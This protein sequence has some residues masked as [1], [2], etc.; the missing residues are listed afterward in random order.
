MIFYVVALVLEFFSRK[1]FLVHLGKDVLGLNTTAQSLL[2]FLNIAEMGIGAAIAFALYRPLFTKDHQAINEILSLMGHFY[3][4][5]AIFVIVGSAV[6]FCFF[7]HIFSKM[8]LPLWYAY[9][10]YGALLTAALVSYWFTYKQVILSA[11]QQNYKIQF[12]Y[13]LPMLI[14][15][16]CQMAAV[17]WLDNGFVWWVALEAGFAIIS[18][19][20]IELTVRRSYPFLRRVTITREIRQRYRS[21]YTKIKQLLWGRVAGV[22]LAQTS[23]LIIYAYINLALVTIYGNYMLIVNGLTALLRAVFNDMDG[24]VGNLV[25]SS[26]LKHILKVFRELFCVRF[27]ISIILTFG[28]YTMTQPFIEVWIGQQYLLSHTTLVL[29]CAMLYIYLTRYIVESFIGAYGIY[30]DI[31]APII[32]AIINIGLSILLGRYWGLNGIL[33]GVLISL[34]IMVVCWKP[35]YLYLRGFR[36]SIL[37]YVGIYARNLAV[38][39]GAGAITLF[40]FGSPATD[41]DMHGLSALA[42][43]ALETI[44]FAALLNTGLF[45]FR[46]GMEHFASRIRTAIGHRK[47]A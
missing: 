9:A 42:Y 23:P 37:H 32:E 2:Q 30:G 7:P 16:A 41:P 45:V 18:A 27:M 33:T 20:T 11:D 12:A 29:I 25:A 15:V 6:L 34:V 26:G 3:R 5:V 39:V 40:I 28:A 19:A 21:I 35:F 10:S 38:A 36:I 43:G 13:R 1:I 44:V 46:C 4:R 22:I 24:G 14:K 17:K 31:F 47:Q 8:T